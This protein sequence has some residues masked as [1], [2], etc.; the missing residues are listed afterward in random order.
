MF[1]DE[2]EKHECDEKKKRYKKD[3]NGTYREEK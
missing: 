2:K 3:L 1:K